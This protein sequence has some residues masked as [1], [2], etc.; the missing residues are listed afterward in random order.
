M[1]LSHCQAPP[2]DPKSRAPQRSKYFHAPPVSHHAGKA[3]RHNESV[4]GSQGLVVNESADL[5]GFT[6]NLV[7]N[8]LVVNELGKA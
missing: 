6:M 8:L 2:H 3:A 4:K 7:M 1:I 5:L